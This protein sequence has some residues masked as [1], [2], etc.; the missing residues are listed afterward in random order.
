MKIH[1]EE[2]E[3][4]RINARRSFGR[5]FLI[6]WGVVLSCCAGAVLLF[7]YQMNTNTNPWIMVVVD[8]AYV[9]LLGLIMSAIIRYIAYTAYTKPVMEMRKAARRVASGDFTVRVRSQ[10]R[11][12]K[13]D[14]IEVLIE[15]FNKMVEELAT[16]ETL[17]GDFI[18]NIS[19][20]IKTPLAIIQ[21][22]ASALRKEELPNPKKQDY[23]NTIIG[24]SR[25]LSGLVTNVLRLNKLENQEIIS[26]QPYLL[27][28]QLRC[29]ILGLEDLIEE[30]EIEI[31]ANL[32]EVSIFSDE[33]LLE[34]VWNNLLTNALKFTNNH[35][36]IVIDLKEEDLKAVVT[37]KDNGCG[38]D[39][40]TCKRIFDRFYQ[41]D[42]S[43]STNGNGLGLS[44]VKRVMDMIE[45]EIT[46]ESEIGK[47]STFQV[48][49]NKQL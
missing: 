45:G 30:K 43:H 13:K 34:I 14:E 32:A 47:G 41:G 2:P 36:R 6:V 35:G 25:K 18:A 17:K 28:E 42:T 8:S 1:Y 24:A 16:I 9:A 22:Y 40:E 38:M 11:D 19:H 31:E 33:S 44:M 26:A 46:V 15:D 27:D 3:D 49:I 48:V 12:D 20:E 23:I 4:T 7:L 21:S 39:Q 10:R 37:I 5:E 29:C